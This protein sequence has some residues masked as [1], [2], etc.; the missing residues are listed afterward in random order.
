M[1]RVLEIVLGFPLQHWPA[2]AGVR[3]RA[4]R[5]FGAELVRAWRI[6]PQVKMRR[7]AE[8]ISIAPCRMPEAEPGAPGCW[9][10]WIET[11][12]QGRY[13][14]AARARAFAPGVAIRERFDE[15]HAELPVAPPPTDSSDHAGAPAATLVS[16]RRRGRWQDEDGLV[17]ELTLDDLTQPDA[18]GALR[19]CELRA[20]VADADDD[21][22]RAAALRALF[23]AVRELSGAWPAFPLLTGA[24]DRACQGMALDARAEPVKTSRVDLTGLRTQRAALFALGG[25]VTAQW[26]ANEAGARDTGDPEYVHQMRVALRR[27]R[28][29]MRLFPHFADGAWKHAF[30]GELGWLGGL[31]G[32]VRDW[33]V[34][35]ASTLPALAAADSDPDAWSATL[36]AAHAHGAAARTELRQALGSARYAG[37]ALSWLEWLCGLGAPEA[38]AEEASPTRGADRA[39]PSLKRHAA[40]R[41]SRL[42]GHLYG[43][44]KLT[45]LDAA[46]R[47]QVRIDAKRLRYALEFFASLASRRTRG[48]TTRVLARVQSVLGDANDAAVALRCLERLAAPAYQLGFARG[49]GAAA[50]RHAAREAEGLLRELRTPKIGGRTA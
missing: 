1:S 31:L 32:A 9:W 12:D 41:V 37:L 45:A 2:N 18:D 25:N 39:L 28:T 13:V 48:E 47:H 42:F 30:A 46:A 4:A 15:R 14:L 10:T 34:C 24:L 23:R 21:T 20:A 38:S 36:A 43:A 6:C 16:M 40:K 7:G 49:Y 19:F 3:G 8:R 29:L 5:D 50:Q 44:P 11:T 17:I 22:R 27:L 26:F 33:D 35:G